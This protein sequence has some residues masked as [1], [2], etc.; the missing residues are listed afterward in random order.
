[1][2]SAGKKHFTKGPNYNV[3]IVLRVEKK[4]KKD[5]IKEIS[6]LKGEIYY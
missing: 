5:S 4:K 3:F 6:R 2:L 1:M